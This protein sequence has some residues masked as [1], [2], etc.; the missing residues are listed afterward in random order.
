M[1]TPPA[2]QA[3]KTL[4]APGIYIGLFD[5]AEHRSRPPQL[6]AVGSECVDWPNDCDCECAPQCPDC[7]CN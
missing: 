6:S 2:D 7:D 1:K 4:P 5:G 3:P